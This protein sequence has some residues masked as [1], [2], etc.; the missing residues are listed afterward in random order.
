S[1]SLFVLAGCARDESY[2]YATETDEPIYQHGKALEKQGREQEALSDFLKVI[3]KRGE[4]APESHLE[5]GL[6]YE[7]HIKDPIAAIYH[8]RKYLELR[9]NSPQADLVRQ[10]IGACMR[11]F[12]RTLPGQPVSPGLQTDLG[13]VVRLQRENADLRA[14]LAALRSGQTAPNGEG[15]NSNVQPASRSASIESSPVITR[16]PLVSEAPSSRVPARPGAVQPG[17]PASHR[18]TVAKGDTLMNISQRYYGT[19]SKWRD[20]YAA[21]RDVMKNENDLKIGMELKIP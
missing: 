4:D 18:H 2:P 16:A 7:Q 9:P 14:Q 3:A 21:N 15:E 13:D 11:D 8:Y 1:F 12:A 20:I 19:R 5:A 17:E 6:L 10:R